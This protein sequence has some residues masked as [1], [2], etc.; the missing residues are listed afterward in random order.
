[1]EHYL[2]LKNNQQPNYEKTQRNHKCTLLS[3]R[4]QSEKAT[5]YVIPTMIFW[6]RE[7]YK[8]KSQ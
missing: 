1:M 3:K 5:K 8:S 7:N 4:R 6:K 2:A